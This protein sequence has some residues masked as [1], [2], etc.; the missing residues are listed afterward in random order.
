M[1]N[2][3]SGEVLF[4]AGHVLTREESEQAQNCGVNEAVVLVNNNFVRIIGNNFAFIKPCLLYTS[5]C[6]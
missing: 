4:P 3:Y 6:V 2:P 1:V 5:R